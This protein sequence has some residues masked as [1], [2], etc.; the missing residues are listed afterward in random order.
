MIWPTKY[1]Q[2]DGTRGTS[3]QSDPGMAIEMGH[4][5]DKP[6]YQTRFSH[7]SHQTCQFLVLPQCWTLGHIFFSPVNQHS[8]GKWSIS[9][10]YLLGMGQVNLPKNRMREFS[11]D[12][13]SRFK[14]PICQGFDP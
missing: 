11:K 3:N 2:K 8:Y 6:K 10:V 14:V 7:F 5:L 9:M 1:G 12:P 4:F 13:K